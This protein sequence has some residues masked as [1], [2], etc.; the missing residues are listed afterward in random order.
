MS[1]IIVQLRVPVRDTGECYFCNVPSGLVT[2]VTSAMPRCLTKVRI[3]DE[4]LREL[5]DKTQNH[6]IQHELPFD[7]LGDSP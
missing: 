3:C 2:V 5:R 1:R 7:N 4:C 6:G